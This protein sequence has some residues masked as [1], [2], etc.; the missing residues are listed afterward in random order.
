MPAVIVDDSLFKQLNKDKDPRIQL[1]QST[2]IGVNVKHDDQMEKAN[3][4]FQQVNKKNE[5]L[6]RLDTSAAQKSLFGIV[7]FIVGFLGLTFLITSGCILYFKQMGESEDEK[8]SYTILRKLGFTQGDLIKGIRIK[9]MYNFGIPLVVG[10][11]HSYF[12]V[13]S[14]WFLFGSEVWAPMIMVM[15]LYTALYSIFGFL[16]VLYYKKVIKSSL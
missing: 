14:G 9:Q 2:F 8:P 13:Q 3:E 6:S 12:A 15:V 11:F 16:S 5:H 10:L 7:M 1:A 4:L